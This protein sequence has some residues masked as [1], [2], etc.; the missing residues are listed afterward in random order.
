YSDWWALRVAFVQ[1]RILDNPAGTLK[2]AIEERIT[3]L[4][5]DE[6]WEDE[7][8]GK[9]ASSSFHLEC[10]LIRAFYGES[11]KAKVLYEKAQ[12]LSG[13]N[14]N[15]TGALGR[16]TKFQEFDVAQ[17]VVR[18]ESAI[19]S[20][21]LDENKRPETLALNDD[22]LLENI[23]FTVPKDMNDSSLRSLSLNIKNENPDDGLTREQM[24]PY[25]LVNQIPTEDSTAAERLRFIFSTAVP[26]KWEL[27]K[28]LGER[29]VSLGV[30]R[31]A[32]EI[33]E[34]L[35]MWDETVSCLQMLGKNK[36]VIPAEDIVRRQLEETPR[37]PKLYCLLGDI[38][39]D[40]QYYYE[41]WSLSQ[42]KYA[43]AMR[44][45]GA[46]HFREGNNGEAWTNLASV[47]LRGNR[48]TDLGE[49]SEA[50]RSMQQVL[51]LRTRHASGVEIGKVIDF[52]VLRIVTDA[53]VKGTPSADQSPASKLSSKLAS[54]YMA[55]KDKF[56]NS[57]ELYTAC[58]DFWLAQ[59]RLKECVEDRQRAYRL[60]LQSPKLTQEEEFFRKAVHYLKLYLGSLRDLGDR[61]EDL[62]DGDGVR[63]VDPNWRYNGRTTI[64]TFVGRTK[65]VFDG[66]PELDELATLQQQFK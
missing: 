2:S 42:M 34:R 15:V 4:E 47:Y 3:S 37:S 41:A 21:S 44:S 61:E 13:L 35:Q 5:R 32:L 60:L 27:E 51:D 25:A 50:I 65:N 7:F 14:W 64:R 40:P 19:E 45:L 29:F 22:T 39:K 54:L 56:S 62:S 9:A 57:P 23:M 17:L 33:F 8:G 1:Q 26:P 63:K 53:V 59:G 30:V 24:V 20:L 58:A 10:G 48:N 11:Q 49:F 43:R 6:L 66:H 18:A 36:E 46:H 52:D 55:Y 38:L 28:E 31:S 16:R 12:N